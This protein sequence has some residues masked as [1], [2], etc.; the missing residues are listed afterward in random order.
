MCV[1]VAFLEAQVVVRDSENIGGPVLIF[2]HDEWNAFLTGVR[3]G[4]LDPLA[5][6]EDQL[7]S[8]QAAPSSSASGE[9][10]EVTRVGGQ[11]AIRDPKDHQRS[12]LVFDL[13]DWRAFANDVR[14][15]E[16]DLDGQMVNRIRRAFQNVVP[17]TSAGELIERAKVKEHKR[18]LVGSQ[19]HTSDSEQERYERIAATATEAAQ[20]VIDLAEGGFD[21]LDL[22][23]GDS[24]PLDLVV[25][26]ITTLIDDAVAL[27]ASTPP[28]RRPGPAPLATKRGATAFPSSRLS[29]TIRQIATLDD[30]IA[31]RRGSL[32]EAI[33][34][35]QQA[36]KVLAAVSGRP[37][38]SLLWAITAALTRISTCC[39]TLG[40]LA[41]ERTRAVSSLAGLPRVSDPTGDPHLV[42]PVGR[43]TRDAL[44]SPPRSVSPPA[45]ASRDVD[46]ERREGPRIT[47]PT[48]F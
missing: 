32:A 37:D 42:G 43:A 20:V 46:D 19:S 29:T 48:G 41:H 31:I 8:E 2:T 35:T 30:Q 39:Q 25:E 15:G 23:E 28:S 10:V 16:F 1:E 36:C 11:V 18:V 5:S 13:P 45:S 47:G 12:T 33:S 21:P 34:D 6:R 9:L 27:S 3:S 7:R 24:D 14:H 38:P 17:T 4:E 44:A 40:Q 26:N 22:A